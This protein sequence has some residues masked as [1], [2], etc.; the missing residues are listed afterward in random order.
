[1]QQSKVDF[2]RNGCLISGL[3]ATCV[4]LVKKPPFSLAASLAACDA[5]AVDL[6]TFNFQFL[7]EVAIRRC[8]RLL[9]VFYF[10]FKPFSQ[11]ETTWTIREAQL[12][13]AASELTN[14]RLRQG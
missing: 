14:H 9:I 3:S 12:G 7:L 1:M 8:L 6:T 13:T 5:S 2:K 11:L 4:H 10:S